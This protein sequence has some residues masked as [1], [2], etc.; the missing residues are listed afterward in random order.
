ME[1]YVMNEIKKSYENNGLKFDGYY[2][3][4][5]HQ[6]EIDLVMIESL[7]VHCIEIKKEVCLIKKCQKLSTVRT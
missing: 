1:T 3:R 6:N 7:T 4:D 5:N 2:Y